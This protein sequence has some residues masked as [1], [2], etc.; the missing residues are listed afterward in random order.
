MSG[1][2]TGALA[3]TGEPSPVDDD[4]D[5]TALLPRI[6]EPGQRRIDIQKQRA[7]VALRAV[8]AADAADKRQYDYGVKQ[9]ESNEQDRQGAIIVGGVY[10]NPDGCDN[11]RFV[12]DGFRDTGFR[13]GPTSG[14]GARDFALDFRRAWRRRLV[15]RR[16]ARVATVER[17]GMSPRAP[18]PARTCR[19]E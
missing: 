10:R 6:V 8:E 12:F 3:P 11:R 18:A 9:L 15:L 7:E 14:P 19:N 2:P 17:N 13:V 5:D 4:P 1:E 16:A